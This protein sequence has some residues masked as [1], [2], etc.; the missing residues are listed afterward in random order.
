M[1]GTNILKFLETI[2]EINTIPCKH[3]LTYAQIIIDEQPQKI[4]IVCIL[5]LVAI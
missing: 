5:W 4:L 2:I 3:I 1:P